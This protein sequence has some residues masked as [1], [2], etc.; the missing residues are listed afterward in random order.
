MHG[1][2]PWTNSSRNGKNVNKISYYV[3]DKG[4]KNTRKGTECMPQQTLPI[5]IPFNFRS[6]ALLISHS[7]LNPPSGIT[8]PIPS[9]SSPSSAPDLAIWSAFPL[10]W[11]PTCAFT[12]HANLTASSLRFFC[13]LLTSSTTSFSSPALACWF[14]LLFVWLRS[15]LESLIELGSSSLLVPSASHPAFLQSLRPTPLPAFLSLL[16]SPLGLPHANP[17]PLFLLRSCSRP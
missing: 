3:K 13:R 16:S 7:C 1:D 17:L 2:I 10:P 15:P 4:K 11:V 5:P 6:S 14:F 12:H 8:S 9:S